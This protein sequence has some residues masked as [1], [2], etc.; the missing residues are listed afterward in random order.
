MLPGLNIKSV[1][2]PNGQDGGT[3]TIHLPQLNQDVLRKCDSCSLRNVCPE[4]VVSNECA[5]KVPVEIRTTEQ[6]RGWAETLLEIQMQR[7]MMLRMGEEMAAS[8]LAQAPLAQRCSA[9]SWY[10]VVV[11]RRPRHTGCGS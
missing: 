2:V 1:E 8:L 9:T 10:V 7:V 11:G 5:F 6:L 4:F 3:R